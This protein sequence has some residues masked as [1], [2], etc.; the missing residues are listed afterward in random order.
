MATYIRI[1]YQNHIIYN[2]EE[3]ILKMSSKSI[4]NFK[5]WQSS[6]DFTKKVQKHFLL[7]NLQNYRKIKDIMSH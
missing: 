3:Y 1:I 5:S 7:Q 4:D 2:L 6:I